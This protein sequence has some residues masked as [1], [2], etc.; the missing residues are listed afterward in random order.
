MI[1]WFKEFKKAEKAGRNVRDLG[2]RAQV[3]FLENYAT[4]VGQINT[5]IKEISRGGQKK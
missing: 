2:P 1:K 4:L 5:Q 3:N